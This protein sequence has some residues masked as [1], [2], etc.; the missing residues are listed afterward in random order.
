MKTNK[1]G[2]SVS[3]MGVLKDIRGLL[4]SSREPDVPVKKS[5]G[6]RLETKVANLERQ[7]IQYRETIERYEADCLALKQENTALAARLNAINEK[8]PVANPAA[9]NDEIFDLEAKLTELNAAQA[10]IQ[11][12][13]EMKSRE[14]ANKI[15]R[16]FNEA[17]Q[18]D[19]AIEFRKTARDLEVAENFA[20]FLSILLD[21]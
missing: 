4:S 15:A 12:V 7:I 6:H 14:L 13:L 20:H 18:S 3:E 1:S 8:P 2:K 5:A 17:G 11:S 9:S 16:V 19:I 21:H 10:Q